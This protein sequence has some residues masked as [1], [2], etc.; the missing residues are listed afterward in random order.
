MKVIYHL[1]KYELDDLKYNL[2]ELD[3]IVGYIKE[4]ESVP[5][6]HSNEHDWSVNYH[7]IREHLNVRLAKISGKAYKPKFKHNKA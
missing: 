6:Y 4:P 7:N 2:K 3:R 5:K 1:S